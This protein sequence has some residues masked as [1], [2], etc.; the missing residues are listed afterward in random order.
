MGQMIEPNGGLE[1]KYQKFKILNGP[2]LLLNFK[3]LK[4]MTFFTGS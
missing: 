3:G 2:E 1:K 4:I